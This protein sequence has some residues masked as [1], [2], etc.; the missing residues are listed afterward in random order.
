M[1]IAA[2]ANNEYE[3]SVKRQNGIQRIPIATSHVGNSAA[4]G[5]SEVIAAIST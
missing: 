5:A 3:T 2:N 1:A 4:T